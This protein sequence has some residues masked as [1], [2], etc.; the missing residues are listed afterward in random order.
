MTRSGFKFTEELSAAG[1]IIINT[2]AFIEPAV[3]ESIDAVLDGRAEN[4]G[5]LLVVAG[6]MPLRYRENLKEQLP[7]V[8]LFIEPDQISSLPDLL[9]FRLKSSGARPPRSPNVRSNGESAAADTSRRDRPDADLHVTSPDAQGKDD[10]G[11]SSRILT[12]RGYAYLKIAE[13]CSRKCRYCTIPSIRGP[14]RSVDPVNLE[15]EARLLG[16]WGVRELVLVAQDLTSYGTDLGE[17]QGLT[18][19]LERLSRVEK[20]GWIRLMYLHPAGI[21]KGISRVIN[22]SE[23]ILPYL[24]IPFQHVSAAVL[25]A[26][27]RPWGKDRSQC[28]D[29]LWSP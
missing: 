10:S 25:K 2:C 21:P 23:N 28:T 6:C 14:F 3:E 20:I 22:E 19:L 27:G 16:E 13:G 7:E 11:S 26:M 15:Q 5:A 24:D 4:P 9:R 12:T 17:K 8:D 1:T 18:H 29:G